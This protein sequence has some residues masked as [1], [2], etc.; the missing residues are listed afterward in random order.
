MTFGSPG[1]VGK[2]YLTDTE[3]LVAKRLEAFVLLDYYVALSPQIQESLTFGI[4]L[5]IA[6]YY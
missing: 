5:T 6:L 2:M 1:F 3:F 4:C